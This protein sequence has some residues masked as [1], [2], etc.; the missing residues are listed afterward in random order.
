MTTKEP[1]CYNLFMRLGVQVSIAGKIY[2]AVERAQELHCNTMQIFT[3]S[4]R[5]YRSGSL[6]PADIKEFKKLRQ[7]V[8]INPVVIHM[9]YIV[10]LASPHKKLYEKSI[11]L[12]IEEIKQ[13]GLLGAEYL[14]THMGSHRGKGEAK[15]LRRF[16][17][18]MDIILKSTQM[19]KVSILLENTSG[20]GFS[21]GHTFEHVGRVVEGV[22]GHKRLGLCLDTC[23]AF[24]AGYNIATLD[25]L[26]KTLHEIDTWIGLNRLKVIHLNDIKDHLGSQRDRHEQIG[27]GKIGLEGFRAI[28]NHHR[29]RRLPF[30][31]E[32]PKHSEDDDKIN[33]EIIR[34]IRE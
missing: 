23:H 24:A 33:L 19:T 29:L 1:L 6:S 18:G 21:V 17:E 9:P 7:K 16:W 3:H 31:L 4:P 10:N 27:K 25:G 13:A 22:K 2:K 11:E 5:E 8:D 20:S 28:V 30:I 34:R 15:G 14:V 32:T 26:N 12:Y